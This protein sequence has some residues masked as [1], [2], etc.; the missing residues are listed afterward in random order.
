MTYAAWKVWLGELPWSLRWF[1]ALVLVRP[2]IDALYV[3]KEISP[4]LSPLY[5]VGVFTPVLVVLAVLSRSVER[6]QAGASDG[7]FAAWGWLLA[8][9]AFVSIVV[10]GLNVGALE[11]AFHLVTP[12]FLYLFARHFVRSKRD[13]VGFATTFFF[14]LV[15]P[16]GMILFETFVTPIGTQESRGLVR[17]H[18]AYGDVASY[19]MFFTAGVLLAGYFFLDEALDLPKRVRYGRLAVAFGVGALGLVKINHGSSLAIFGVLV[20]LFFLHG[21]S[22]RQAPAILL[23]AV[24]LVSGAFIFFGD[25]LLAQYDAIVARELTVMEREDKGFEASFHGRGGRWLWMLA[26]WEQLPDQ[27][28]LFGISLGYMQPEWQS[29]IPFRQMVLKGT[30]ND[31]I[32]VLFATGIV[33]L[34]AFLLFLG[35]VF[36]KSFWLPRALRFLVWGSLANLVLLAVAL[37]PTLYPTVQYI[38]FVVFAYVVGARDRVGQEAHVGQEAQETDEAWVLRAWPPLGQSVSPAIYSPPPVLRAPLAS[39][40]PLP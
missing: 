37:T 21:L 27:A 22:S 15:V 4:F 39:I 32:R 8:L 9:S 6:P 13:L 33:G 10:D 1:V 38:C 26:I 16:Y 40:P 23:V 12:V 18:G 17:F 3:L 20:A 2:T 24:A 31:Y 29:V 7:L 19:G 28:K 35:T 11:A 25:A 30:H 34:S 5:I 36:V 14:S